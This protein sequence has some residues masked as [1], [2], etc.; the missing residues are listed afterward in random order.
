MKE[1]SSPK[2]GNGLSTETIH[3]VKKKKKKKKKW[4]E[5]I[6][7]RENLYGFTVEAC[8]IRQEQIYFR[9]YIVLYTMRLLDSLPRRTI[10][11][12]ETLNS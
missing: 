3:R 2:R 7:K 8:E 1:L 5:V 6:G 12:I 4:S 9:P 10:N 11:E